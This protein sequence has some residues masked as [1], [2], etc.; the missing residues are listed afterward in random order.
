MQNTI[1]LV[2]FLPEIKVSEMSGKLKGIP[3]INTNTLSNDFC[4]KMAASDKG[5][6]I[7]CSGCYSVA[8]LSGSRKNCVPRF[9]NNTE[10]LSTRPLLPREIPTLNSAWFRF[11]GHGELENTTHYENYCRIAEANPQTTF[12]LWTKRKAIVQR[13][14]YPTPEN[15]ILIYSN[16][17]IDKPINK[18]PK[19]F[20]KVFNN[21]K[22]NGQYEAQ[23]NC[24]GQKCI[25]CLACY[26]FGGTDVIVE[27][28]KVRS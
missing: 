24:T 12:A 28:V 7:I 16:P 15:L 2:G 8:M 13:S 11:S 5:K 18:A 17:I 3:A 25:E 27:A 14:D 6:N 22:G 19:G 21:V 23:E 10:A 26:K 20:H 9:Q 4:K 1:K